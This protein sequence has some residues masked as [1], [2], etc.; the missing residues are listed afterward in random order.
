MNGIRTYY[1]RHV[2]VVMCHAS[3]QQHENLKSPLYCENISNVARNS[4]GF[5]I[6]KVIS[7]IYNVK[8][9]ISQPF[10]LIILNKCN[11]T[12]NKQ[13]FSLRYL[14]L[15]RAA[16]PGSTIFSNMMP[17][18]PWPHGIVKCPSNAYYRIRV[19]VVGHPGTSRLLFFEYY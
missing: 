14:H 4:Y 16:S 15:K 7:S 5:Q 9:L 18:L 11:L 10:T 8:L 2:D 17:P 1:I 3:S 19:K 12:N 6:H 13:R